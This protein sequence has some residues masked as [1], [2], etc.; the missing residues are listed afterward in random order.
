MTIRPET[1]ADH[2]AVRAVDVAAF[3]DHPYSHQTEHLIVEALRDAGALEVSLVA[4]Q[5]GEVGH[6][7]AFD[8]DA[9]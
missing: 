1:A 3:T 2:A 4:E 5:G 6:H 7:P 8:L 9:G